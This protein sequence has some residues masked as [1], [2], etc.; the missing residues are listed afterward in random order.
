MTAAHCPTCL[1]HS[2]LTLRQRLNLQRM[3][4]ALSIADVAESVAAETGISVEQ[5]R[6]RSRLLKITRARKMAIQLSFAFCQ[7]NKTELARAFNT[8]RH[9]VLYYLKRTA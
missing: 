5:I 2:R 6:G 8:D 7:T 1:C 3:T 4:G 9:T